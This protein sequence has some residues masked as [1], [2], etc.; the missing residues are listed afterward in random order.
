MEHQPKQYRPGEE[1]VTH[2]L[3]YPREHANKEPL[4]SVTLRHPSAAD[5]EGMERR[6]EGHGF[7]LICQLSGLLPGELRSLHAFDYS[8]LSDI[9]GAFLGKS[10]PTG[11]T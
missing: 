9:V 11:E 7:W 5:M 3:K 1:P 4:L 10:Q 8:A 2:T 6:K